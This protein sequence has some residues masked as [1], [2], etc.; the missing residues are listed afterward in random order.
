MRQVCFIWTADDGTL[1]VTHPVWGAKK[2][3]ES[4]DQF[5]ERVARKLPNP[6]AMHPDTLPKD[7]SQRAN[8]RLKDGKVVVEK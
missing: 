2:P 3:H 6:L 4:D 1:R 5:L 8:W 7:R